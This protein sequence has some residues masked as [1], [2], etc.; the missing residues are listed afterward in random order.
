MKEK[1]LTQEDL[2]TILGT[3]QSSISRIL[4]GKSGKIPELVERIATHLEPY[5]VS[6][7]LCSHAASLGMACA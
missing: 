7:R 6:W 2:G 5:W 1:G 3:P 4:T